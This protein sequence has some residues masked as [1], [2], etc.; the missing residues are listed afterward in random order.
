MLWGTNTCKQGQ[1]LVN[2]DR[3]LLT[4]RGLAVLRGINTFEQRQTLVNRR[5]LAVLRGTNTCKQ[6]QILVNRDK[7]LLA[8]RG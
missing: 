3:Y 7:Y 6:G 2:M 4:G 5:G 1:I 8:G